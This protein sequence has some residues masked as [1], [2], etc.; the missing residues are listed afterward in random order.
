MSK[1]IKDKITSDFFKSKNRLHPKDGDIV[2]V[3]VE[4]E[5]DIPFWKYAFSFFNIKT[6]ISPSSQNLKRGK[7][8]VLEQADKVGKYLLLCLDSDYD[9]IL[10]NATTNSS[11]INDNPY[12]FQTYTYSIENYFCYANAFS[13]IIAEATQ[14]DDK[15]I[16]FE[17]FFENYSN[18]IFELFCYSIYYRKSYLI[19]NELFKVEIE[20]QKGLLND[21]DLKQWMNK[22]RPIEIFSINDFLNAIQLPQKLNLA[23][24]GHE[25]LAI[26]RNQ[27]ATKLNNLPQITD[28]KLNEIKAELT[29]LNTLSKQTYLFVQGHHIENTVLHL[30]KYIQTVLVTQSR[31][32]ITISE[33]TDVEKNNRRNAYKNHLDNF[34]LST[35]LRTHKY[36]ENTFWYN[37]IRADIQSYITNDF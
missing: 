10:Q 21:V 23:N 3:F 2:R 15:I 5:D 11:I 26:I 31:Q 16:D 29:N 20:A 12:I 14:N 6:K 35:A 32:T 13:Q 18:L 33:A 9:Y 37:K 34:D 4:S 27:I 36:Y 8:V 22:N 19:E 30:L 17:T 24:N 1:P 25:I 7:S 28:E